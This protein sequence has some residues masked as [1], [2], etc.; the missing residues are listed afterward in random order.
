M[1]ISMPRRGHGYFAVRLGA[2][3]QRDIWIAPLDSP[4]ALR[5]FLATEA[6]EY[7]PSVSADGKFLAY[8]S[9]ESGRTEVYV[10]PIPGPGARVQISLTGGTEPTWSPV[11]STVFYRDGKSFDA[12]DVSWR[13]GTATVKRRTLFPDVYSAGG[14]SRANYAVAP[15][16]KHFLFL[17]SAGQDSKT[18]VTE[19]WFEEVRRRMARQQR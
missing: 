16:G 6:D 11:S 2:G 4:K 19:N 5:P 7:Q 13:G 1:E 3:V 9:D 12:A 15:D 8:V 14:P 17:K 18:T 10:R